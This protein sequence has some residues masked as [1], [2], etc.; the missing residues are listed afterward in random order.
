PGSNP[1]GVLA[2]SVITISRVANFNIDEVFAS[3]AF[4]I[5]EIGGGMVQG[6]F[7]A[8]RRDEVYKDKYDSQSEAGLVGGSA[9]NSAGGGRDVTAMYFEVL[10]PITNT[11]EVS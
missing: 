4:D 9:G 7:G 8:E 6:F 2:G 5:V 3:A 10:A 1:A 11:F